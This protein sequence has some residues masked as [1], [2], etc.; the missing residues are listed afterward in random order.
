MN[1]ESGAADQV[2]RMELM[3]TECA[4]KMAANGAM[5]IAA[6]LVAVLRNEKQI[7]GKTDIKNST[8]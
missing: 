8:A 2:F 3:V 5:N 6:L 4:V 7:A 1:P